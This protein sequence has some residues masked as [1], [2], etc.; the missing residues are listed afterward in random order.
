M[1]KYKIIMGKDYLNQIARR[2]RNYAYK[3][4]LKGM[5]CRNCLID[6]VI[7]FVED[8]M[9]EVRGIIMACCPKFKLRIEKK[10]SEY[11]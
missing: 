7:E 9:I 1:I 8:D 10:L 3:P 5:H 2:R 11:K 4:A 6:T